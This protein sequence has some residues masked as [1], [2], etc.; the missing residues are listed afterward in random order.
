MVEAPAYFSALPAGPSTPPLPKHPAPDDGRRE[1]CRACGVRLDPVLINA[2]LGIHPLCEHRQNTNRAKAGLAA[3]PGPAP[4]FPQEAAQLTSEQVGRELKREL[5]AALK[6]HADSRPRSLQTV[7]GPSEVGTACKRK[8]AYKLLGAPQPNAGTDPWASWVGTQVHEGMETVMM[9]ANASEPDIR[10][11][12]ESR[13]EVTDDLVGSADLIDRKHLAVI[14]HKAVGK[15]TFD[16]ARRHGP[17]QQ[18]KVQAN[19][20][21]YG[22]RRAG[23]DI[24]HTVIVYWPRTGFKTEPHVWSAP[25]DQD[26]AVKALTELAGLR[27]LVATA[28]YA[29]LTVL[30]AVENH[31]T[32]CPF[33][34]PNSADLARGC[35]GPPG[36]PKKD[37]LQDLMA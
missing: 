36:V 27:Q 24:R 17:S 35:P 20:Y 25:Y 14:D 3:D 5:V 28:G 4:A 7:I 29:A 9:L 31:C 2:G 16:D 18:Y 23:H 37:P 11:I 1:L 34:Q 33:W 21:A 8:L 13:V 6:A 12:T 26:L 22:L 19:L 15:T 10:W 30:P 32:F